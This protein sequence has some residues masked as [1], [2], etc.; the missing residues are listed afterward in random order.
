MQAA[1]DLSPPPIASQLQWLP[2]SLPR[3]GAIGSWLLVDCSLVL[4]ARTID[5]IWVGF[6]NLCNKSRVKRSSIGVLQPLE[7]VQSS[8]AV[9]RLPLRLLRVLHCRVFSTLC[10]ALPNEFF[11]GRKVHWLCAKA[12]VQD[13]QSIMAEMRDIVALM[14]EWLDVDLDTDKIAVSLAAFDLQFWLDQKTGAP[15]SVEGGKPTSLTVTCQTYFER[16][17]GHCASFV[18]ASA[19]CAV[20]KVPGRQQAWLDMG[21]AL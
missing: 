15:S 17:R 8:R 6:Q 21:I 16:L 9:S 18:K 4:E 5:G 3:P 13:V 2:V 12:G 19:N 10:L 14:L 7:H 20:T 1:C 11:Y